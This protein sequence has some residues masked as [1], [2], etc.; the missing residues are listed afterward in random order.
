MFGNKEGKEKMY[1]NIPSNVFWEK[2]FALLA[3]VYEIGFLVF[4]WFF[5][6][7]LFWVESYIMFIRF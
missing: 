5:C 6:V 7:Q 4:C 3:V 2:A 1:R